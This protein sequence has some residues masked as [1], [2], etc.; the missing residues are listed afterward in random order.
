MGEAEKLFTLTYSTSNKRFSLIYS[1]RLIGQIGLPY[2]KPH[3]YK[4]WSIFSNEIFN[5]PKYDKLFL[6][7]KGALQDLGGLDSLASKMEKE[8][9]KNFVSSLDAAS[10]VFAHSILDGAA[11][12]YCRVISF[13]M[14]I[15]WEP[16]I[17][18][19]KLSIEEIR[20]LTH[21]EILKICV[22]KYIDGLANES[23]LKKIKRLFQVCRPE[24]GFSS[25]N[26]YSFD[27]E[28][29]EALDKMRHEIVHGFEPLVNLPKGD[30]DIWFLQQ[31]SNFLMTLVNMRFNIKINPYLL[32]P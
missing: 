27:M 26:N 10:L 32:Y 6:D 5:D 23:L 21:E 2:A 7:K 4:K 18:K 17:E 24:P 12:G 11:L 16:F 13:A 1:F 9:I 29:L 19:K 25:I 30:D 15:T 28:R 14:P 31:T 3:I 8:E 20:N 22:K